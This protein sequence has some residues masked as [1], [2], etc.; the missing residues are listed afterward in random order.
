MLINYYKIPQGGKKIKGVILG[1]K[2]E[3]INNLS[4]LPGIP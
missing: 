2:S 3:M 1:D 4:M